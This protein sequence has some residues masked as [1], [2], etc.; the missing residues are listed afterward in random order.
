MAGLLLQR[1]I[2]AIKRGQRGAGARQL[3]RV[4]R[5]DPCDEDAW[6]WLACATDNLT[7]KRRCLQRYHHLGDWDVP[8]CLLGNHYPEL[9]GITE[10]IRRAFAFSVAWQQAVACLNVSFG[11]ARRSRPWRELEAAVGAVGRALI[12]HWD[13]HP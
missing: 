11:A 8:D 6:L 12:E 2:G 3:A 13:D 10:S 5:D 1:A 9:Q 4:L 7:L